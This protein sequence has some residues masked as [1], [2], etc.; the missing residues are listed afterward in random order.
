MA[1]SLT[2][3]IYASPSWF[4]RFTISKSCVL[5]E[6]FVVWHKT[7]S[8]GLDERFV[9]YVSSLGFSRSKSDHSLFVFRHEHDM[10]YLLFYVD[11]IILNGSSE[12]LRRLIISRL[13]SKFSM[14]DLVLL[15]YFLGIAVTSNV[16]GLFLLLHKYTSDILDRASI[17]SCKPSATPIDTKPKPIAHCS[18]A[19][20]DPILYRSLVGAVQ[21]LMF[22][23]PT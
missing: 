9:D 3:Y 1:P 13:S 8:T 10:T 16:K 20:T 18:P 23:R 7:S 21:Y 22:T 14:K 4:S 6:K 19:Y 12:A 17:S 5:V 11:D 2:Q 15:H